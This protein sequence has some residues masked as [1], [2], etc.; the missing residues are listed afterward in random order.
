[1]AIVTGASSGIG[2]AVALEFGT[3]GWRVALGARRTD[4]LEDAA[5]DV[6]DR[7]GQAFVHALDVTDPASIGAFF[8]AAGDALGPVDVPVHNPGASP[9]GWLERLPVQA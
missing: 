1:M 8:A 9:P 3:L 7:G 4:R 2:R 6:R 5:V